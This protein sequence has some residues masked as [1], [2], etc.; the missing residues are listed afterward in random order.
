MVVL[1]ALVIVL[2]GWTVMLRGELAMQ[3]VETATA[4]REVDELAHQ[5]G[6]WRK[7][8]QQDEEHHG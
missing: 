4:H 7:A 5:L 2:F 1:G 8:A 3:R 6:C